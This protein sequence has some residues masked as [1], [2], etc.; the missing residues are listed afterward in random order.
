MKRLISACVIS[1]SLAGIAG[2]AA[3]PLPSGAPLLVTSVHRPPSGLV[4]FCRANKEQCSRDR[5]TAPATAP[6][7]AAWAAAPAAIDATA[8]AAAPVD[9]RIVTLTHERL[10]ELRRVNTEIN[11]RIRP[12]SDLEVF[13]RIDHW[14]DSTDVGDCDDYVMTKRAALIARGWPPRSLL[15]LLA[16]TERGERHV[17]LLAVTDRG[18]M[19]LDNRF[20]VVL[21]WDR[22]GYHWIARQSPDDLLKWHR[23]ARPSKRK[24]RDRATVLARRFP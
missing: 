22:V 7:A 18:D 24:G 21:P 2:C 17:V 9:E 19:V 16:D 11:H 5:A 13:G 10:D 23:V 6:A 12:G 14:T 4:N 20:D 15:I 8:V 3:V 1:F